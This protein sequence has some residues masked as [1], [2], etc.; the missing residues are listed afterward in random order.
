MKKGDEKQRKLEKD[1]EGQDLLI[2]RRSPT[3]DEKDMEVFR[4]IRDMSSGNG[5]S[6]S[7]THKWERQYT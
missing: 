4:E 7:E 6:R 5:E 2:V 1:D 3:I